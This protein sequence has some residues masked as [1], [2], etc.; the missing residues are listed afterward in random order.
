MIEDDSKHWMTPKIRLAI[1]EFF[2][3]HFNISGDPSEEEAEILSSG[4]TESDSDRTDL[5]IIGRRYDF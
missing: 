4:R 1:Y 2:M 3:K 5:N